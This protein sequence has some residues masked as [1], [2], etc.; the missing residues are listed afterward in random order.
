VLIRKSIS[1]AHRTALEEIAQPG[2]WLDAWTRNQVILESRHVKDCALCQSR[3]KALSPYAI[4]GLHDTASDLP[5]PYIEVIHRIRSDSGRLTHSW[6]NGLGAEMPAEVYIELLGIIACGVVIDT[7]AEGAGQ[8]LLPTLEPSEG[9]PSR[10]PN[11]NVVDAG[12]WLPILDVINQPSDTGLPST[13]NIAR[14]MGLVPG[15]IDLFFKVMRKHYSL[16]D[17]DFSLSRDQT[18]MLAA[19]V[20]S[21]NQCFY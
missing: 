3:K 12:A 19:R 15:S 2:T 9:D 20:S 11:P 14:A 7:F 8:A 10:I 4:N 17:M 13:P 16:G 21:L 18:E 5:P 6:F 1:D